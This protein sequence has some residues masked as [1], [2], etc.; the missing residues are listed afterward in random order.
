MK[1]TGFGIALF[2]A[3]SFIAP[4]AAQ[5]QA[6]RTFVSQSGDDANNCLRITPCKT[7]AGTISK[8]AAGGEIDVLDSG[9]YGNVTVT[10]SITID[11]GGNIAGI[12]ITGQNGITVNDGGAGAIVVTLRNLTLEGFGYNTIAV[13]PGV[14]GVWF[15]SGAVL[16]VQH[17]EIRNYRDATNGNGILFAPS[18]NA[19]LFVE[20]TIVTN[21][22]A[23]AGTGGIVILP[24]GTG[25]AVVAL[26]RVDVLGNT[27]GIRAESTGSTGAGVFLTVKDGEASGNVNGG[28]IA[29]AQ[30]GTPPVV[31]AID[32]TTISHNGVGI[33]ANGMAATMRIGASVIVNNATGVRQQNSSTMSSYGTNQIADNPT[34]G[35][36]L[37]I[38]GPT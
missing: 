34:P 35:S 5:A 4:N 13:P 17:C 8:T 1:T 2:C 9:N 10:K 29:F 23:A 31:V 6:A 12:L 14:R 36:T 21:N 19:K 26:E 11:G 18:T 32:R 30:T 22:G 16:H 28:I 15:I 33:N 7:F 24:T 25:S 20:D 38:I 37:T 27:L 3:A